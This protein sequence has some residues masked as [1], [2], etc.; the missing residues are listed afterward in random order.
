ML[1]QNG[2]LRHDVAPSEVSRWEGFGYHL[3]P[4]DAPQADSGKEVAGEVSS[5][6]APTVAPKKRSTSRK[7]VLKDDES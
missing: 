1:M 6:V 4:I 3:V 2:N 7:K 5:P